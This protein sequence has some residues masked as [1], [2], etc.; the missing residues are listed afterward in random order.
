M[1]QHYV[2]VNAAVPAAP[3]HFQATVHSCR[4]A[5]SPF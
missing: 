2:G 3:L 1:A 5:W 4:T